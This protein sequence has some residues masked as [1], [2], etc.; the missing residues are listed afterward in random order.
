MKLTVT[1][2]E[3]P[4]TVAEKG[5]S[6]Q[7]PEQALGLTVQNLTKDL[8]DQFGYRPGEGVIVSDVSPGSPAA[9]KGIQQSD[10]IASV[11][12]QN[13]TSVDEFSVEV[14]QSRK[15]GKVLFLVKRGDVSQ[16]VIVPFE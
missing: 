10:L 16:F 11:N 4:S 5:P 14:Q 6:A 1:L 13:V 12:R 3:R 15:S 9:Q 7:V 8:S 2:G